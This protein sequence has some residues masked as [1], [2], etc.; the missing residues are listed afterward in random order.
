MLQLTSSRVYSSYNAVSH[1]ITDSGMQ[2][3]FEPPR[4]ALPGGIN[5]AVGP[6][7]SV[8]LSTTYLDERVRLGRGGRGSSFVFTKGGAS[9]NAGELCILFSS[10][11]PVLLI[12]QCFKS[13]VCICE[14]VADK[15][16]PV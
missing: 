6:P 12:L 16:V 13:M 9:D 8:V 7:S 2:V 3:V 10:P 15:C 11:W 14:F 4:L 1:V 5:L